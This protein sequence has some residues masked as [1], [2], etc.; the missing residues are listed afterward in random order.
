M[1]FPTRWLP[2]VPDS[3]TTFPMELDEDVENGAQPTRLGKPDERAAEGVDA[4]TLDADGGLHSGL[5]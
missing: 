1:R 3:G 5:L 4:S 2:K